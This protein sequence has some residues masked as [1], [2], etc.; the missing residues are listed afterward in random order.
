MPTKLPGLSG[1]KNTGQEWENLDFSDETMIDQFRKKAQFVRRPSGSVECYK[2]KIL[3]KYPKHQNITTKN[4]WYG[5]VLGHRG[6]VSWCE[7]RVPWIL[8]NFLIF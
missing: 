2:S 1:A 7:C 5:A 4:L 8:L 6:T 3:A